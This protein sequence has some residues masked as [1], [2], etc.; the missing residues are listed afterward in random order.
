MVIQSVSHMNFRKE[1]GED[2]KGDQYS[3]LIKMFSNFPSAVACT[4]KD[5]FTT[6]F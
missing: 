4:E 5:E 3:L 6:R 1:L 2:L